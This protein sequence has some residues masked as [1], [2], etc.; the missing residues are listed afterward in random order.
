MDQAP[1]HHA[2]SA[3]GTKIAD[4][5]YGQGDVAGLLIPELVAEKLIPFLRE[6][7]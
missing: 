6:D 1:C 4:R 5:V 7:L 3:H 2:I